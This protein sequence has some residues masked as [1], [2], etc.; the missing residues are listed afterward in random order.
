MPQLLATSSMGW[1][2]FRQPE[3]R[4]HFDFGSVGLLLN[5]LDFE[6]LGRLLKQAN[7]ATAGGEL[8]LLAH[9]GES[10]AIYGCNY[11]EQAVLIF[12]MVVL[13]FRRSDLTALLEL[14]EET[15]DR[16]EPLHHDTF[17]EQTELC[18][19]HVSLN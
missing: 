6:A 7:Q 8:G 11:H 16:L 5:R 10:R 17:I 3:N 15:A 12:D 4:L 14:W 18:F 19:K 9:V 2:V 13:R 1:C